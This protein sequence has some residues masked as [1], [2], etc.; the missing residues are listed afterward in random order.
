VACSKKDDKVSDKE[1]TVSIA[2]SLQEPMKQIGD[3]FFKESG[4]KINYNIGG[5]GTLEKQIVSGAPVDI[6]FSANTKYIEDLVHSNL[7]DKEYVYPLL[8][9]SLVVIGSNDLKIKINTLDDLKNLDGKIGIGDVN[10]VPA[11][12]YA[13]Q[14]LEYLNLWNSLENKMIFSKSVSNVK[15][16]VERGETSVGFVYKTDA[17]NLEHSKVL[18]D[19]PS[20]YHTPIEYEACI[21]KDSKS[22]KLS[23]EFIEYLKSPE[24]LKIFESYGFK[25]SVK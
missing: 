4:I 1:L 19:I 9:N 17:E 13:K 25:G 23:E 7:V 24:V 12:Q 3:E 11:G 10:T 8:K 6:F 16:Y 21:L 2:A 5:S 15:S 20:E 14:S 22:K 18:Y